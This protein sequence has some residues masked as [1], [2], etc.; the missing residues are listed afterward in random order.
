MPAAIG[1]TYSPRGGSS[2]YVGGGFEAVLLAWSDNSEAFGPSQGRARFD[3][4]VLGPVGDEPALGTMV[5]YRLGAQVSFERNASRRVLIPFFTVDLGGLWTD[6]SRTR[7][8]ADGGVGIYLFHGRNVIV[9]LEA[10]ALLPF[11]DPGEYGGVRTR[12]GASFSL[13]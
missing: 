3:I 12:L 4:A 6:A 13:W 2:T 11:K 5:M 8:F 1:V 9:D 7:W 10:T